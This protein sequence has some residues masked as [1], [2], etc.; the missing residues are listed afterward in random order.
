METKTNKYD[1]EY[2]RCR[3]IWERYGRTWEDRFNRDMNLHSFVKELISPNSSVLDIGCSDGIFAYKCAFEGIIVKGVDAS[4]KAIDM[5]KKQQKN[6]NWSEIEKNPSFVC[7]RFEDFI[8]SNVYDYV[9]ILEVLEHLPSFDHAIMLLKKAF[10]IAK[11]AV[12][13]SVPI[14]GLIPDQDHKIEFTATKLF[15]IIYAACADDFNTDPYITY[16]LINKFYINIR[17]NSSMPNI[18]VAIIRK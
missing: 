17:N 3:D 4:K 7:K 2:L 5:A 13:L 10:D 18:F 8:T 6:F 15:E 1:E 11:E 16:H 12:I 14:N 9:T